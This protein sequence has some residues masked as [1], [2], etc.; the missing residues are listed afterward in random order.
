M[1]IQHVVVRDL[2]LPI[3]AMTSQLRL[4]LPPVA[5]H[6]FEMTQQSRSLRQTDVSVVTTLSSFSAFFRVLSSQKEKRGPE[7]RETHS[8]STR[9]PESLDV[10]VETYVES[11]VSTIE[12]N[13]RWTRNLVCGI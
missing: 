3:C 5:L 1:H 6:I 9:F 8:R 7:E 12:E 2:T 11:I 4:V 13:I 10:P